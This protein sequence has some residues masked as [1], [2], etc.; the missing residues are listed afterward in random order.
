VRDTAYQDAGFVVYRQDQQYPF[1]LRNGYDECQIDKSGRYLVVKAGLE[2]PGGDNIIIDLDTG[3]EYTILDRDGAVGHSDCGNCILIGEDDSSD[4]WQ[5]V[6]WDLRAPS[7]SHQKLLRGGSTWGN[8]MGHNAVRGNRVLVSNENGLII[9][10]TDGSQKETPVAPSLMCPPTSP[11]N[12][13]D[14]QVR[15]SWD[16]IAE[17][18][19]WLA[20]CDG[21]H[22]LDAFL[23]QTT[24]SSPQILVVNPPKPGGSMQSLAISTDGSFKEVKLKHDS[25]YEAVGVPGMFDDRP[26]YLIPLSDSLIDGHGAELTLVWD[27]GITLV[28]H[29]FLNIKSNPPRFSPNIFTKPTGF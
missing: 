16:P 5:M 6:L 3:D 17:Y 8:G 4:R 20:N 19:C 26:A 22:R 23:V 24:I 27:D 9:V 12:P 13:Y 2:P 7:S 1:G 11:L 21:S 14:W 25:G 15:A 29:G 28:Q 10:S 18:A